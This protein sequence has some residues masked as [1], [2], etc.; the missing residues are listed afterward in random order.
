MRTLSARV[1][2]VAA[3]KLSVLITGETGTGKELVARVIHERSDRRD[4]PFV[5]ENC[6]AL[7]ETLLESELFG[8]EVG[9]FTGASKQRPGLFRRADGGT[10]F[11]DEVGDMSLGLQAK[12]L[13]VIEDGQVRRVGGETFERVNVRI[14]AA[15][16]R[17]LEELVK[18]GRFR[19][20]LLFRLAV[21]EVRVPPLRE[22]LVDVP[23][24]AERCLEDLA[25]ESGT[26][27]LAISE[28]AL[29]RLLAH[30]WPGNVREL[31]NAVRAGALFSS[32][33]VLE[34]DA[35]PM[36]AS[37][38]GTVTVASADFD[39]SYED[40]LGDLQS[41]EKSYITRTLDRARGNKA[42]SARRLGITRYA[43][44]RAMRRL[45]IEGISSARESA[46]SERLQAITV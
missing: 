38:R 41:R 26:L 20:D 30:Y 34:A 12:L 28:A 46:G 2:R 14:L 11:I 42:E 3:S 44:Y 21:L 18:A 9:S 35:L 19:Q 10:L 22:R 25:S 6:A 29:D 36:G 40:L 45:G 24:L 39:A 4:G 17:N 16:H 1:E 23:A 8:H 27:P 5:S 7:P 32:G 33:R 43:L 31:E 15:T 37:S 13:R